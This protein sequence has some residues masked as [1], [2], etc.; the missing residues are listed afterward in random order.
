M[1]PIHDPIPYDRVAELIGDAEP[2]QQS[3]VLHDAWRDYAAKAVAPL[4]MEDVRAVCA[5]AS[6]GIR[7]LVA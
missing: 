3:A 4:R 6:H 7:R 1:A 2:S 5:P